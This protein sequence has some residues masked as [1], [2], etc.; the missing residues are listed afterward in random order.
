MLQRIEKLK[1]KYLESKPHLDIER[2]V[3]LT[4]AYQE[5]EDKPVVLRSARGLEKI[6]SEMSIRIH[7]DELIVG[8]I[9]K[10]PR[11]VNIFPEVCGGWLEKELDTLSSRSWDP[12]IV[13]E[14]DKR[15]LREE[16]FPYWRGKSV[17]ERVFA[18][19][20]KET[21][22]LCYADPEVYP[23]AGTAILQNRNQTT[24]YVGNV[25]P[26][27]KNVLWK[28][29]KG[30]IADAQK[31]L[32]SLDPTNPKDIEKIQFLESVLI[33]SNAAIEFANRYSK[34]AKRLA[35]QEKDSKRK[36]ELLKIV[37]I[38]EWVPA[39]PARSYHEALQ[40]LW[41][42]HLIT[43][44]SMN[45][46]AF[47]LGRL[48]QLLFPFYQ[49]D[50]KEGKLNKEEA[51]ELLEC[52]YIKVASVNIL[53]ATSDAKFFGGYAIWNLITLG[54]QTK[55]GKE[56]TNE[57]SYMCLEA[58]QELQ[59]P[60]PDIVIRLHNGTPHDFYLQS[61]KLLRL[62]LGHPK[63][64]SDEIIIP[65]MLERGVPLD[66]AREYVLTA[67]V[68]ARPEKEGNYLTAIYL[69]LG[70][71]MELIFHRGVLKFN[72]RKIGLDTGDPEAFSSFEEVKEAYHKQLEYL[73][74]HA[75]IASGVADVT[76]RELLAAPF[77]SSMREDCIERA[78]DL[79]KYGA[80]YNDGGGYWSAVGVA[81]SANSL[82]AIKKLVFEEKKISMKELKEALD[83]NFEGYEPLRQMLINRAPKWGNDDDYVDSLGEWV[84]YTFAAECHKY[85]NGL[86]A[87][88]QPEVT[89]LTANIPFGT[90]LGAL[91]SG[92]KSGMPLTD[93]I[94]PEPNSEK[95]GVIGAIKSASKLFRMAK[96]IGTLHNMKF[97]P[98]LL[99]DDRGMENFASLLKTYLVDYKGWHSQFNVISAQTLKDAQKHPENYPHLIIKV[100]G[101]SAYFAELDRSLQDE[102]IARTEYACI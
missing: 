17:D 67:C 30:I 87:K 22:G 76:K 15:I 29:F 13:R 42:V 44:L 66:E 97:S 49:K 65:Y 64:Q 60:Q 14:E 88:Y 3:L 19:L 55:D 58:M 85:R 74:R 93:G 63:Y 23:P 26:N 100:A 79:W 83:K 91:P 36:Q 43:R 31:R 32:E 18:T 62:G 95:N 69:N 54:G 11:S 92:R 46:N 78:Q 39:N 99:Q 50:L 10:I 24:S 61:I 5:N 72:N 80:S 57:I 96:I 38:T 1:Q 90:V 28:G 4:K 73:S 37:E 45:G 81:D 47:A 12:L 6:L 98:F 102:I 53:R 7:P 21:K 41:F 75:A 84:L 86:G 35:E 33:T 2:G 16:I 8:D 82:A 59:L 48:D 77:L 68:E 89:T 101:Y 51:V 56:A 20:Q 9:A 71:P 27:Y 52:F 25:Y 40:S 94:S 70:A 34:E